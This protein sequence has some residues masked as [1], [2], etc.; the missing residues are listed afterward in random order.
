MMPWATVERLNSGMFID[1]EGQTV[2]ARLRL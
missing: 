2:Y 1:A